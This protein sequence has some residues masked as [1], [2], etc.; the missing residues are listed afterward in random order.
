MSKSDYDVGY[1]RPPKHTQFKPGQSGNPRGRRP[2]REVIVERAAELLSEPVRARDKSGRP[3][4]IRMLEA[5]YLALCR[6]ALKGERQA[7]IDVMRALLIVGPEVDN[8]L[9]EWENEMEAARRSFYAKL[10]MSQDKI[11]ELIKSKRST[12]RR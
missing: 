3:R 12:S 7:L 5:S 9:Q 10:G 4:T 2:K 8:G 11:D 1:G 6:K